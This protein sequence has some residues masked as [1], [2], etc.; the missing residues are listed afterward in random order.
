MNLDNIKKDVSRALSKEPLRQEL[1][2]GSTPRRWE[3][4][5]GVQKHNER[6]H[7]ES[8]Y[9]DDHK[10]LPFTFRKPPKPKGR[11]VYV[12][13]DNCGYI[14][15]GSTATVGMICPECKKYSSV[16]EVT[17]DR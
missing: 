3:P 6:I 13:C 4:E 2:A 1:P 10:N 9:A 12:Q 16:T 14:T 7:R 15:G 11:S 8:K 17:D 5:C